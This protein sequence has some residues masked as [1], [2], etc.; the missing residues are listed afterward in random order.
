MPLRTVNVPSSPVLSLIFGPKML[1]QRKYLGKTPEEQSR[2]IRQV[3]LKQSSKLKGASGGGS[4][5]GGSG[6]APQEGAAYGDF[7]NDEDSGFAFR[8]DHKRGND[9]TV[10]SIPEHGALG[11]E[12]Q[13][14]ENEEGFEEVHETT[15]FSR[16]R[17]DT[18]TLSSTATT[19]PASLERC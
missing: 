10:L 14:E 13:E 2:M 15:T 5:S 12:E 19:S 6:S 9:L 7:G 17:T 16:E 1:M 4:H 8:S 18:D 3:A 11:E